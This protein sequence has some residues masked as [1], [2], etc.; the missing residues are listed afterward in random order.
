MK[1]AVTTASCYSQGSWDVDSPVETDIKTD[2]RRFAIALSPGRL[3]LSASLWTHDEHYEDRESDE[4]EE[5]SNNFMEVG[6]WDAGEEI[7]WEMVESRQS[8]LSRSV[9]KTPLDAPGAPQ[10][11]VRWASTDGSDEEQEHVGLFVVDTPSRKAFVVQ[12]EQTQLNDEP[13]KRS[14]VQ[15]D[16]TSL[17]T[18]VIA[19]DRTPCREHKWPEE[20]E[21]ELEAIDVMQREK[22]KSRIYS[23]A[24]KRASRPTKIL[25]RMLS[26]LSVQSHSASA[27]T[28]ATSKHVIVRKPSPPASRHAP[29]QLIPNRRKSRVS[30]RPQ[31][32]RFSRFQL[33]LPDVAL[34]PLSVSFEFP[35][36]DTYKPP[37]PYPEGV[38]PYDPEA[39]YDRFQAM[40]RLRKLVTPL[41]SN[42]SPSAPSLR[43]CAIAIAPAVDKYH[44]MDKLRKLR[45]S[46]SG[47]PHK[48]SHSNSSYNSDWDFHDSPL[49]MLRLSPPPVPPAPDVG[50]LL[51][52][53]SSSGQ[54]RRPS[55][56]KLAP[57]V[58][59]AF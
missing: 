47:T 3:V 27:S 18:L 1:S 46:A 39:E 54:R 13:T 5:D 53:R 21:K 8:M 30:M 49:Q 42:F 56:L 9:L 45:F 48:R 20:M 10:K 16:T 25:S 52:K 12:L 51:R 23:V 24:Y 6:E 50:H 11:R 57:T 28:T 19:A 58:A 38:P 22:K 34:S 32:R 35:S 44:A 40:E 37:T 29:K 43:P 59:L 7:N 41:T 15:M 26:R 17:G 33:P 14:S 31:S 36:P 2:P 55:P 4:Y